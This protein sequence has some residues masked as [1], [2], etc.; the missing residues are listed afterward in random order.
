MILR[1]SSYNVRGVP[2]IPMPTDAELAIL[3]VLWR[4]G[5]C[6]V[7][8]VHEALAATQ[9]TT[10]TTTLK[11]MQ[12][13]T[14]KGLVLRDTSERSHVFRAARPAERT[15]RSLVKKLVDAAFEGSPARLA[16]QALS[17]KRAS[18]EELAELEA[19]IARLQEERK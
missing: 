1:T 14:Q 7:R 13:M 11:L 12:L 10:Y 18:P 16:M 15:Q 4:R 19:L 2:K 17:T 5:P 3:A 6:T 8:A 9:Q